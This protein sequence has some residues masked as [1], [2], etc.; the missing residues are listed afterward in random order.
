MSEQMHGTPDGIHD[1][2]NIFALAFKC[3]AMGV[4]ALA[5]PPPIEGPHLEM[6]FKRVQYWRPDEMIARG[7]VYK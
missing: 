1:G 6:A 5:A 4:A 7:A 3:I 2:G